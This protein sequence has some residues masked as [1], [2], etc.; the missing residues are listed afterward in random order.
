LARLGLLDEL[1]L[2]N[3]LSGHLTPAITSENLPVSYGDRWGD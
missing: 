1:T 2:T 3:A